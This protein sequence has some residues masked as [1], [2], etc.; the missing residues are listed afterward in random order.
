MAGF[1][2]SE[3]VFTPLIPHHRKIS[4]AGELAEYFLDSPPVARGKILRTVKGFFTVDGLVGEMAEWFN[5]HA[6][7]A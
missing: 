7:K 3:A 4:S 6:W 2:G 5:A 1:P